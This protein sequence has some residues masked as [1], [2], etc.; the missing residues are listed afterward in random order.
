MGG[1][2]A[3]R[4]GAV[5]G[6]EGCCCRACAAN[7][8]PLILETLS[9]AFIHCPTVAP[10]LA[11]VLRV[12][13]HWAGHVDLP[14]EADIP[15]L[16]LADLPG[17]WP[18]VQRM[19]SWQRLRVAYLGCVWAARQR[20]LV[21][22]RLHAS[23][24][25]VIAGDVAVTLVRAIRRDSDRVREDPQAQ[26]A[27]VGL[28]PSW[29]SGAQPPLTQQQFLRRWPADPVEWILPEITDGDVDWGRVDVRLSLERPVDFQHLLR[30]F[31]AAAAAQHAAGGA[32]PV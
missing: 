15:L 8:S 32:A 19:R 29:W 3:G 24:A 1:T 20:G 16:V 28:P 23:P 9:H 21:P 4:P 25:A 6:A 13:A 17:V 12:V 22:L 31:Q 7:G 2:A 5:R 30:G 26:A 18:Q 11:W 27:A 14:P 10:V